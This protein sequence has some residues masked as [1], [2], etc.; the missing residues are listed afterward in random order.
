MDICMFRSLNPQMYS[1]TD[2]DIHTCLLPETYMSTEPGINRQLLL[3]GL[4]F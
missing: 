1:P 4:R 3:I 2:L